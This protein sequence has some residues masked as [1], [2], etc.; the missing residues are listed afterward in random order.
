MSS[1]LSS[2]WENGWPLVQSTRIFKDHIKGGLALKQKSSQLARINLCASLAIWPL[3]SISFH[4]NPLNVYQRKKMQTKPPGIP[5]GGQCCT[6]GG[7]Y[8][9]LVLPMKPD[10]VQQSSWVKALPLAVD[11]LWGNSNTQNVQESEHFHDLRW[12]LNI[13]YN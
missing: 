8:R 2:S 4:K 5:W 6:S 3:N 7:L 13:P 9:N 12:C 11:L 1:I 10:P